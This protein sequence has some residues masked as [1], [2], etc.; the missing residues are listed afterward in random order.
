MLIY[1]VIGAR[2][3]FIKAAA[4]SK[5]FKKIN[6]EQLLIQ[7]E[8]IHTGQ[9]YDKNMSSD[10]FEELEIEKPLY[11]LD[12]NKGNHGS[13]TG[14]MLEEIEKILIKNKPDGVLIYGDTDSTLAGALAASKLNIPLFHIEA[15]LRSYN[16][17]QPEEQNRIIADHLS[18]ICFTPTNIGKSNL[19]KESI[20][21]KNIVKTGD[22]MADSARIFSLKKSISLSL[23]KKLNVEFKN[24]ILLTIHRKENTDSKKNL[25]EIFDALKEIDKTIIFPLHPRTKQRIKEYKLNS[26]IQNLKII[27]PISFKEMLTLEKKALLIIT[28]SGGIQ[29]EAYMQKTPSV[30]LRDQTEWTELLNQG[31]NILATP[32]TKNKILECINK[33]IT[34]KVDYKKN[35]YGDGHASER[36]V[37]FIYNFLLNK[38][39]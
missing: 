38:K 16:K 33:Q 4:V 15:G 36:I 19:L 31:N 14:R 25:M 23:I 28:D 3:Q 26:F 37:R 9:H 30:T 27:N 2:P 5:A 32:L 21:E 7:E 1:T 10:F 8:I 39:K 22:V 12:I 13:N 20:N 24:F 34:T 6:Q 11:N 35:L 18:D 29:K 17:S